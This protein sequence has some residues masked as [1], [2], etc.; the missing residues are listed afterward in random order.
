MRRS[1]RGIGQK[2]GLSPGT[3]IYV[4]Q[5]RNERAVLTLVEY[6]KDEVIE[7]RFNKVSDFLHHG[8]RYPSNWI[9]VS[10]IHDVSMVGQL[11]EFFGIHPLVLEDIVNTHQRPKMEDHEGYCYLVLKLLLPNHEGNTA[12]IQQISLIVGKDYVISFQET[13]NRVFE[14]VRNRIA[15]PLGRMRALGTDYLAYAL[16]DAII[17]HYYAV[18]ETFGEQ[19][20]ALEDK[21]VLEPDPRVIQEIHILKNEL[22]FMRRSVWPLREVVHAIQ[23]GDS[24][25]FTEGTRIYIRD[26]YDHTI[27]VIDT[28]EMYRDMVSGALDVCLSSISN[29]LN[30][31]MKVL[32]IISTIFIPLN[33]IAGVYGMNF[34][35]MPEL[36]WAWGY[37]AVL[38]LMAAVAV[39]LLYFFR[40]RSWL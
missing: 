4:G 11:G 21:V 31:V 16:L 38:C 6:D 27:Q 37:P 13:P 23:R 40:K 20:E 25:V 34:R 26:I 39:S 15:G 33:F 22:L 19:I 35:V 8:L 32:T 5:N 1:L 17:D 14:G 18:L 28:L 10:G 3:L 30:E 9:D 36:E 12:D 29:R 7:T 2:R 24:A